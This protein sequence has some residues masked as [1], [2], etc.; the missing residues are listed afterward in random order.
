[1][2]YAGIGRGSVHDRHSPDVLRTSAGGKGY[3]WGG[4]LPARRGDA[5]EPRLS[6]DGQSHGAARRSARTVPDFSDRSGRLTA[7]RKLSEI[8]KTIRSK[9]AGVDKITFDVI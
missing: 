8:A 2:P 4:R 7:M 3:R 6:L 5:G 9:N 1:S